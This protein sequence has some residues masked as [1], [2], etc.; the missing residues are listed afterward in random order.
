MWGKFY[1]S[2]SFFIGKGALTFLTLLTGEA[3]S[4]IT[5]GYLR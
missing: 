2:F 1:I 4:L 5:L 3:K